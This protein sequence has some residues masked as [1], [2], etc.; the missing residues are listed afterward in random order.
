MCVARARARSR[1]SRGHF[2]Q[3][4]SQHT[5][6]LGQEHGF[7]HTI[8][9][10]SNF[11]GGD[12]RRLQACDLARGPEGTD[13]LYLKKLFILQNTTEISVL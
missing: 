6:D 4:H 1:S 8:C 10:G 9:E 11:G 12:A 7:H 5:L 3:H 13:F 2:D